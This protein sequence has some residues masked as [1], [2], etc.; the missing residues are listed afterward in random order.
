MLNATAIDLRFDL[1]LAPGYLA[2]V[3]AVLNHVFK[4]RL[5]A[6]PYFVNHRPDLV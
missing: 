6:I 2:G 1:K 3:S 4:Q 5:M